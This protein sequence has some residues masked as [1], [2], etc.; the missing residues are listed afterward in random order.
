MNVQ[1]MQSCEESVNQETVKVIAVEL[2]K[3][4]DLYSQYGKAPESLE[5]TT[6]V[7]IEQLGMYSPEIVAY[8]FKEYRSSGKS[9]P[10]PPDIR[11]IAQKRHADIVKIENDRAERQR[12][13]AAQEKSQKK[14]SSF[15]VVPWHGVSAHDFSVR[16]QEFLPE[17]KQRFA[18]MPRD[19][20]LDYFKYLT[21]GMFHSYDLKRWE[22]GL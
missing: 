11:R 3:S 19:K 5:N 9:M 2:D 7:F 18:E 12:M 14:E 17:M 20:A 8:A 6:S 16:K 15:R 13:L 22:V 1:G 4:Y 21:S 10:L